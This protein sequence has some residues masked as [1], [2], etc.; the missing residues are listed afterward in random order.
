MQCIENGE[1]RDRILI[2]WN[3]SNADSL[4]TKTIVLIMP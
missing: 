2:Q 4:G 3:L 1:M